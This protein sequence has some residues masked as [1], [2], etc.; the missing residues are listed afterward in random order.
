MAISWSPSLCVSL[1]LYWYNYSSSPHVPL[2]TDEE[3]DG[4]LSTPLPCS[5]DTASGAA[6][7]PAPRWD[8]AQE[9]SFCRMTH[10]HKYSDM[11]F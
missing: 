6:L 7:P 8:A 9:G 11:L 2:A 10:S 4:C 5:E 1:T 3:V